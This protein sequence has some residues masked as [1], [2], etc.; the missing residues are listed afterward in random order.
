MGPLL[1]R[2]VARYTAETGDSRA[3]YL[4][5]PAADSETMGARQHPGAACH[6]QAAEVL[7]TFLRRQLP[8]PSLNGVPAAY[9]QPPPAEGG[10]QAA[11]AAKRRREP[12]APNALWTLWPKAMRPGAFRKVHI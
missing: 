11:G 9:A 10:P 7:T 12:W 3:F 5:L 4:P 2:A 6:R 1:R 8:A